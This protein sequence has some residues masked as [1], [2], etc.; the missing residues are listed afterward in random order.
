MNRLCNEP[1]VSVGHWLITPVVEVRQ[2]TLVHRRQIWSYGAKE[3]VAIIID[4]P[5]GRQTLYLDPT[6]PSNAPT[7]K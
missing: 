3:P 7:P 6:R 1:P 4:S 5:A 2:Q